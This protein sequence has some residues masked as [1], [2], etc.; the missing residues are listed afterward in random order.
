MACQRRP[1]WLIRD[2][3]VGF[4]PIQAHSYLDRLVFLAYFSHMAN[5][6]NASAIRP[7]IILLF[8]R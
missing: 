5:I 8:S 4:D 6:R 1:H 3:Q 7:V 2:W